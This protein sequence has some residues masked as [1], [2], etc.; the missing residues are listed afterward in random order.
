MLV[1]EWLILFYKYFKQMGTIE[2][3]AIQDAPLKRLSIEYHLEEI[4]WL[5]NESRVWAL[6]NGILLNFPNVTKKSSEYFLCPLN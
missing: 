1:G 2:F 6:Y 4:L 3:F 5:N